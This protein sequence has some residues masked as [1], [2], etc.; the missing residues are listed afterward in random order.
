MT[1]N[2]IRDYKY[3]ANHKKE[4]FDGKSQISVGTDGH[5]FVI[6]LKIQVDLLASYKPIEM[7]IVTKSKLKHS[8]T[9]YTDWNRNP[10]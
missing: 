1:D 2:K 7:K 9:I 8:R 4:R 5:S 3:N 10:L 6:W